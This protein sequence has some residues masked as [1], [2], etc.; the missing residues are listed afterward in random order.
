MNQQCQ[1]CGS[2]FDLD[3]AVM[4]GLIPKKKQLPKASGFCHLT[5]QLIHDQ[6]T[7]ESWVH[8]QERD[9]ETDMLKEARKARKLPDAR[10]EG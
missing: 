7:C 5:S 10:L 4:L 8:W 2:R 1:H 3:I 6:F 9:L